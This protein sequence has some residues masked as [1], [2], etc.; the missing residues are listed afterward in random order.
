MTSSFLSSPRGQ[1][2][3]EGRKDQQNQGGRSQSKEGA[4]QQQE[5]GNLSSFFTSTL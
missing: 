3:R 4:G 5:G 2:K 1:N